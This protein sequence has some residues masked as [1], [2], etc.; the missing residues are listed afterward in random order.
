MHVTVPLVLG[1]MQIPT[2]SLIENKILTKPEWMTDTPPEELTDQ[3]RK[4]IE[5]FEIRQ[6]EL[7]AEQDKCGATSRAFPF[8]LRLTAFVWQVSKV[9]RTG[10]EETARRGTRENR[11]LAC[12]VL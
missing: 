3:Q 5:E 9:T 8:V 4:E 11:P 6:A 7:K 2:A 12:E 1:D 10:T